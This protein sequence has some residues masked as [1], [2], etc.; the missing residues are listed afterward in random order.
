MDSYEELINGRAL[1]SSGQTGSKS[2]GFLLGIE[3]GKGQASSL[4]LVLFLSLSLV[5]GGS[6]ARLYSN[7]CKTNELQINTNLIMQNSNKTNEIPININITMQKSN[8]T[9]EIPINTNVKMQK[10]NKTNGNTNNTKNTNSQRLWPRK[11]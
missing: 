1:G 5:L 7:T 2:N 6:V 4:S 9:N 11:P 10:N 3:Y 8:K